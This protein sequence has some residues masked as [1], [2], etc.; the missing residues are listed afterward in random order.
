[1]LEPTVVNGQILLKVQSLTKDFPI[2]GNVLSR[3]AGHTRVMRAVNEV[4]FTINRGEVV[5]LVGESGCG[6]STSAL[7]LLRL[8]NATSGKIHYRGKEITELQG[9]E[10]T[11]FR[12]QVQMVF[13]DSHSALNPR[14]VV[15][16]TLHEALRARYG[17]TPDL[18]EKAI[19]L[20]RTTGLGV[21]ILGRY[22]HELSGGQ[23]Q[24]I[25][26]ARA[27]AMEPE[28]IV[29][30]EP[31]SSLD[32]S[33]QAQIINVFQSLREERG[34]TMML[35]SHDLALVNFLCNRVLVM[36]AGE[37]VESGISEQVM[38]HA[39]HPYT[40][41]L[42]GAVPRGLAGRGQRTQ[43]LAGTSETLGKGC[44]FAPRCP[45]ATQYCQ[46]VAPKNKAISEGHTA[47]CH[48]L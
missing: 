37:V 7:M 20:L 39:A 2:G 8:L 18:E 3:I 13:Q 29:A 34:L 36:Y 19:E 40:Q 41:A 28:F 38:K 22:P 5:G 25:G 42:I 30:D 31:V 21:E 47:A 46:E 33:L 10:L 11:S 45:V 6:K 23:R 35:I 48:L 4:S 43:A 15:R 14:K 44:S 26:I 9:A 24:R 27:M 17:R 32:V 16:R 12:R 1:M